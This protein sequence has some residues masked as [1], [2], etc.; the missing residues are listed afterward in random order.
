MVSW[1]GA[2]NHVSYGLL[3]VPQNRQEDEDGVGHASRSSGL[4]RLEASWARIFQSDLETG[5]GTVQIVHVAS[6]WRLRRVE[7]EDGWVDPTG[8]IRPFYPNFV[9]FYVLDPRSICLLV[10]YLGL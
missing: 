9:V 4:L 1:F 2:Q 3:I 5:G 6:S 8:C 10:F 7:A